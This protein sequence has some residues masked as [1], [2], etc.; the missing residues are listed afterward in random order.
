[1]KLV[2]GAPRANVGVQWFVAITKNGTAVL[3]AVTS[4]SVPAMLGFPF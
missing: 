2:M 1:M 4:T 3:L